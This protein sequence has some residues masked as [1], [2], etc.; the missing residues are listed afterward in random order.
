MNNQI[1]YYTWTHFLYQCIIFFMVFILI[2]FT[3]SYFQNCITQKQQDSIYLKGF[4]DGIMA[5]YRGNYEVK[6]NK[7]NKFEIYKVIPKV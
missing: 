1:K 4:N 7:A 5:H 3:I 6:M 2:G